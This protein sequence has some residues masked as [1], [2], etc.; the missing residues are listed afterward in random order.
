MAKKSASK[1]VTR[2]Q[3]ATM[4]GA[5]Y[6]PPEPA[7]ARHFVLQT[8]WYEPERRHAFPGERVDM[9]YAGEAR[10][11]ALVAAGVLLPEPAGRVALAR[12]IATAAPAAENLIAPDASAAPETNPGDT[13]EGKE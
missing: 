8:I 4:S 11:A 7:S 2:L 5:K 10:T 3:R 6:I 13:P 9:A 12:Q 1:K